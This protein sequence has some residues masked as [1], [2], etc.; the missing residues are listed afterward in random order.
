[1]SLDI[2]ILG[3]GPA[4]LTAAYELSKQQLHATVIEKDGIVGGLARTVSYRGFRF[5]IGGHRF[6]TKIPEVHAVWQELLG[7]ELLTRPRLSRIY[8]R[9]RY[10]Y[11]PL[12]L[13][14]AMSQLGL[15]EIN[16]V[17]LSYLWA[18]LFPARQEANFE[19]WVSNRFGHRLYSI[20]FKTYTEKVWGMPCTEIGAEWAAQRIQNLS[21]ATAVW[22][23]LSP[24]AR[25]GAIKTLIDQFEYPRLGPGQMWERCRDLIEARGHQVLMGR[26]VA[27]IRHSGGRVTAV[28]VRD[29]QGRLEELPASDVISSIAL[30]DVVRALS[31]AAPSEVVEAA[32]RLR[33]RD[34]LTVALIVDRPELFPNNWIYIH[35]P[36]VRLGRIQNFKNWS[37][38]MV[39]DPN[40]SGLGLEYFVWEG[41]DLWRMPDDQLMEL[42]ARELEELGLVSRRE[43]SDGTVIRM[44]RAYPVYDSC[45]REAV[46]TIRVYLETLP[47]LQ[48]VGRNGQHRYNNQD[49]SMLTAMLAVRNVLGERNDIWNVNTDA[50]YHETLERAQPRRLASISRA[51]VP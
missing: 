35:S 26:E 49:H 50:E 10:F 7:E 14:E 17:L 24:R 21:L 15:R 39:P 45:Y 6:F 38:D 31:P 33:Y 22:G 2:L 47:N 1:M 29:R 19:Q 28:L 12:R 51:A 32:Q 9:K 30:P 43:V 13:P 18:H 40:K 4:G 41:N 16:R 27:E 11:Y 46:A 8:Y 42:G 23:A 36:E 5:D 3:G 48:Q 37:P 20:F 44:R 25:Q 34:F